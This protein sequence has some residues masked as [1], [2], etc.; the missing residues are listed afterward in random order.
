MIL[1]Q[2]KTSLQTD[3]GQHSLLYIT[4]SQQSDQFLGEIFSACNGIIKR[5]L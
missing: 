5:N 3:S 1:G 4:L 2:S